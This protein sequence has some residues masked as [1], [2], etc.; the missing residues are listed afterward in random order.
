[1]GSKKHAF[2]YSG[3]HEYSSLIIE[4]GNAMLALKDM[5][6]LYSLHPIIL[7]MFHF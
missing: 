1:M 2:R 7:V 4:G 5:I 3:S 6:F